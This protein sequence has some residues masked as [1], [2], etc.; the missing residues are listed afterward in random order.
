MPGHAFDTRI[1]L[2]SLLLAGAAA[3]AA[4]SDG[5]GL[6]PAARDIGVLQ[7]RSS[8][9]ESVMTNDSTVHWNVPPDDGTV[10]PART[11]EVADTVSVGEPFTVVVH[12]LGMD[13]CWRADGQED[14]VIGRV[15][16]ITPY[17]RHSG[18][19]ACGE[20]IVHLAHEKDFTASEAGEWTIRARGR[21]VRADGSSAGTPVVAERV[22]VAF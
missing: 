14:V 17:D 13:A 8:G 15:I 1:H 11:I 7:I 3:L 6:D 10:T 9:A 12:T 22:I 4:C 2:V 5:T 19:D 16:E 21:R 20:M 18:D